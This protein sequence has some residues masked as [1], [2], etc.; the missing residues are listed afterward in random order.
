MEPFQIMILEAKFRNVNIIYKKC[1][2]ILH[3]AL[4][5]FFSI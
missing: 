2:I 4:K 5:N 3:L 1:L